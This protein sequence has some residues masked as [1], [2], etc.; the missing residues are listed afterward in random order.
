VNMGSF[1]TEHSVRIVCERCGREEVVDFPE[2]EF[3]F[4]YKYGFRLCQACMTYW[5]DPRNEL[6][7]MPDQWAARGKRQ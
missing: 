2:N 6:R 7:Q 5:V 3:D 4:E 1:D